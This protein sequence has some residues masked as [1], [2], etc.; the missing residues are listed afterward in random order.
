[1]DEIGTMKEIREK[2]RVGRL[3]KKRQEKTRVNR[4]MS[5]IYKMLELGEYRVKY[6]K[7]RR[8]AGLLDPENEII[9]LHPNRDILATLV[10]EALHES[11]EEK[12]CHTVYLKNGDRIYLTRIFQKGGWKTRA[13]SIKFEENWV[14][15]T[16]KLIMKHLS[17]LQ[18]KR[19]TLFLA[20]LLAADK[21]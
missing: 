12:Y 13:Y 11:F 20:K 21:L 8:L 17:P 4:L 10:H 15:K 6:K 5:E 14:R 18:A 7:M 9:W 2:A 19:L 3:I 16:E 1:M